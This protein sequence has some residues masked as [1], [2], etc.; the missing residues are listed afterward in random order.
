MSRFTLTRRHLLQLTALAPLAGCS[1]GGGTGPRTFALRPLSA[2]E[3]TGPDWSLGIDP[4]HALKG[5][6]SERIAYR[7]GQYEINYYADADWID[8]APDMVQ[9]MLIRSFQNRSRLSVSARTV[10]GT[11]PDFVLTSLL[12]D[13]QAEGGRSAQVTLVASLAPAGHRRTV[14][15]RTFEANATAADEH[16]E[17]M[18]RAFDEAMGHV[19]TDLIAWTLLT[20]AEEKREG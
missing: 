10:G 2:T 8:L 6:D 11:P 12:Q 18:V 14:R 16:I 9:M 20:A 1:I 4:P 13:F 15:T 3:A 17:S 7:A 5:L 19:A